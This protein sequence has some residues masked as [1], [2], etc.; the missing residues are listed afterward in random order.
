MATGIMICGLNGAGKS[1]LGKA[2]ADKLNF[3]YIDNEKIYFPPTA[4]D[5][6]Y[7]AQR[8]SQEAERL[9]VSEMKV[10]ESFVYTSVKGDFNESINACF[11][12]AVMVSAPKAIRVQRVKHRSFQKF[13]NRMLPGGDLYGQE[14]QFFEFVEG[15]TEDSVQEWIQSL[16]CPVLSIDGIRPIEENIKLIIEHFKMKPV[17]NP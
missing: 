7:S 11:Q 15:R 2:L 8:T 9:L 16:K 13:G 1:T 17:K 3:Y 6:L 5:Y 14:K 10:H 12:Y 4:S